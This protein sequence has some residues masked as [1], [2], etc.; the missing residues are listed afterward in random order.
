MENLRS[1]LFIAVL[2]GALLIIAN[3]ANTLEASAVG[4]ARN[5]NAAWEMRIRATEATMQAAYNDLLAKLAACGAK[6]GSY[7][8]LAVAGAD[9]D[10]CLLP[11][12]GIPPNTVAGFYAAACP[13]GWVEFTPLRDRFPVGAGASYSVGATGGANSVRLTVAEM[14]S[15]RHA[16][17]DKFSKTWR[18]ADDG[19][20]R[21]ETKDATGNK[22]TDYE[23]G[24]QPHENRPP[25]YALLF[26]RKT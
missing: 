6:G 24:S 22:F 26:C 8:G 9:A 19:N 3:P 5:T 12:P 13:T 23:G 18:Y 4:E 7:V 16:Y 10:G 25:Y 14:P 11:A 2:V 21:R 1:P 15:H 17:T 20:D